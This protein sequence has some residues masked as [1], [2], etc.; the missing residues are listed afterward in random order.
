MKTDETF[1]PSDI[2]KNSRVAALSY[3][4]VFSLIVLLARRDSAYAQFHARQ[5]FIL[6]VL[7]VALWIFPVLRLGELLLL[8]LMV[9]GF[10]EAAVG[11]AFKLPFIY[12][13][14]RG[15][16]G[17]ESVKK[18]WHGLK[19]GAIQLVKPDYVAPSYRGAL[20]EQETT[21]REKNLK[22]KVED[23]LL[24]VEEKKLSTLI[25][26]VEEDEKRLTDLEEKVKH[27]L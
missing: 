24:E 18:A 3:A 11:N 19:T 15:M 1:L 2:A 27:L 16:I 10:I 21:E 4:W 25:H 22:Q 8:A 5:G 14:S 26:R 23:K 12:E 20:H 6:F 17:W 9:F 13:L 7:S